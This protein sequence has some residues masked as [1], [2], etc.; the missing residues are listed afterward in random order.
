MTATVTIYADQLLLVGLGMTGSVPLE[1]H[2]AGMGPEFPLAQLIPAI[3]RI[4]EIGAEHPQRVLIG[5]GRRLPQ[6]KLCP[7]VAEELIYVLHRPVPGHRR[8]VVQEPAHQPFPAVDRNE[9]EIAG[10]LLPPPTRQHIL[11]DLIRGVQ[12]TDLAERHH[13]T[14]V[15]DRHPRPPQIA[16]QQMTESCTHCTNESIPA[17][18]HT[19]R[20]ARECPADTA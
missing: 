18:H 10:Q 13:P 6:V 2:L 4:H 3:S 5:P 9:R 15:I 16:Q 11:D 1:T 17:G 14:H 12:I 8:G 19:A 20:F 7:H